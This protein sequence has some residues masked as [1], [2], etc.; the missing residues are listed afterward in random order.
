MRAIYE[1]VQPDNTASFRVR[2]FAEKAFTAPYHYHPEYELTLIV[3]G[4]GKR[5]VGSHL[6]TY[7]PGDLVLL[8]P[9]VPHCW[10][11]DPGPP[12]EI[13][14]VSIVG[15]FTHDFMGP[16]FF[17]KAELRPLAQLL[18]RSANGL[19]FV[20]AAQARA[21]RQLQQ[22]GQEPDAL[23]RLLLLLS[24]LQGLAATPEYAVL[25]PH[26]SARAA[27]PAER[28]RFHLV[29]AYL[30]EHFREEITLTQVAGVASLSPSA[31][32]KYF[33]NITR[34]TFIQTVLDYRLQYATQQLVQTSRPV[35]E[36]CYDSGF[37]DVSYFNRTF[38][39][40]YGQSPLQY[41]RTFHQQ[42]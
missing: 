23:G 7:A 9:N 31:F 17:E 38:K 40:C 10:K 26:H 14:A 21:Q 11:T 39:S 32:C 35:A 5:Y 37:Q 30:V 18:Q 24:I 27:A 22:L 1:S 29:M 33:K 19:R 12:G 3:A 42:L 13:R 25:D 20:G 34:R 8:G 2:H 16:A 4:H 36:I 41:R 6:A 28:E 15:H